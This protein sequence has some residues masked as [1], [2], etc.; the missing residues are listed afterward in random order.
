MH[1]L[2]AA[3]YSNHSGSEVQRLRVGDKVVEC[4][5]FGYRHVFVD[6][7]AQGRRWTVR[8][9]KHARGSKRIME[10]QRAAIDAYLT[11]NP[12]TMLIGSHALTGIWIEGCEWGNLPGIGYAATQTR[13]YEPDQVIG[14]LIDPSV[15][16]AS[17]SIG[18]MSK[19]MKVLGRQSYM[20][21]HVPADEFRVAFFDDVDIELP[22][23][24]DEHG[25]DVSMRSMDGVTIVSQRFAEVMFDSIQIDDPRVLAQHRT[26][27]FGG[28]RVLLPEGLVRWQDD[29]GNWLNKGM[30]KGDFLVASGK[31]P[32]D[33]DM[34]L[35]AANIKPEMWAT[36]DHFWCVMFPHTHNIGLKTDPMT[37]L[38]IG[39]WAFGLD[40]LREEM[41]ARLTDAID[42]L[43]DGQVPAWILR[44]PS[45]GDLM[46]GHDTVSEY[47]RRF[48]LWINSGLR[49]NES[50]A[51]T[52][53]LVRAIRNQF[54][55]ENSAPDQVQ[56]YFRHGGR[57]PITTE[58]VARVAGILTDEIELLDDEIYVCPYTHNAVI[59]DKTFSANYAVHGGWDLDDSIC[60]VYA[61][62][63]SGIPMAIGYRQPNQRGEYAVYTVHPE[64]WL[65]CAEEDLRIVDFDHRPMS[66]HEEQTIFAGLPSNRLRAM[67]VP[68]SLTMS[69]A[70]DEH[71]NT[72]AAQRV[73]GLF[74][75]AASLYS[76]ASP[77][78]QLSSDQPCSMEM[79]LDTCSQGGAMIDVGA[80]D[81]ATVVI[82][83]KLLEETHG[84]I[85]EVLI[86]RLH[87]DYRESAIGTEGWYTQ[88]Y[89]VHCTCLAVYDSQAR[90]L[91]NYIRESQRR[92]ITNKQL[93]RF[94]HR[95]AE[96]IGQE[97]A[98]FNPNERITVDQYGVFGDRVADTL[99]NAKEQWTKD[100]ALLSYAATFGD[101]R[102]V[103]GR[104]L[105]M[106][107]QAM[108]DA[109]AVRALLDR[110]EL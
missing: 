19:R 9:F 22:A 104:L 97:L 83:K 3:E 34:I 86:R 10:R 96:I 12:P 71:F 15:R 90:E 98:R 47:Q 24:F 26:T 7:M 52:Q 87:P 100:M 35:H 18:K 78:G 41:T 101:R 20:G 44:P 25:N 31:L 13:L 62:D 11:K 28:A 45:P 82:S 66:L 64:S 67:A 89:L 70:L 103:N 14:D 85:D 80:L 106:Y 55:Q 40:Y 69:M 110:T 1:S 27:R 63:Y 59:T 4:G 73:L 51:L 16:P 33:V 50:P 60:L 107:I 84:I 92:T 6:L 91:V 38:N 105:D 74:I 99:D 42:M 57:F 102:L 95:L 108:L 68:V 21:A 37:M 54:A 46:R 94:M 36:D 5:V 29:K 32:D 88:L 30:V 93:R 75:N 23:L 39:R 77:T 8:H 79:A 76:A 56:F 65:P 53:D 17:T 81:I 2:V 49:L 61:A 109:K 48:Q 72:A 43:S 58:T